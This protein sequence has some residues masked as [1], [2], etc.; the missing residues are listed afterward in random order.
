MPDVAKVLREEVQRLAKRQIKA[1]LTPLKRDNARLKKTVADIRRELTAL[2]RS[3]RELLARVTPVV[4]ARETEL[5]THKAATL[6]PTSKSL[7]RLRGQLGLTQVEFGS[8]LGVSGQTV[9][10]WEGKGGRVRMRAA[11]LEALAGIQKIGKREARR[12]LE[13]TGRVRKRGRK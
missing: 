2:T 6:R 11:N 9:L 13:E 10:N 8:L 7:A 5:A 12:R 4:A 1:A 3:T